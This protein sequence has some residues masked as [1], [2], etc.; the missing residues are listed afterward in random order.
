MR[1]AHG[2]GLRVNAF[3]RIENA[4]VDDLIKDSQFNDRGLTR[5]ET[6]TVLEAY[7]EAALSLGG[8]VAE[9]HRLQQ[10]GIE[11]QHKTRDR[12]DNKRRQAGDTISKRQRIL[13]VRVGNIIS[14][15]AAPSTPGRRYAFVQALAELYI[16]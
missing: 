11:E 5:E 1:V 9:G 13:G 3:G 16:I 10:N 2:C 4:L 8:H 15:A 14:W 12:A 6:S 7:I